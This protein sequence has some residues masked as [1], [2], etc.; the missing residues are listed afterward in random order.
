MGAFDFII[1]FGLGVGYMLD[2]IFEKY[3]SKII[4]VEPDINVMRTAFE[5]VDYSKYL[6][7]GRLFMTCDYDDVYKFY[8][9]VKVP[10]T[11]LCPCSKEISD[12]GAHNQR[13]LV[14][15]KIS[16]DDNAHIWIE[17]LVKDIE[18]CAS[19]EIYSLLKREDE[20]FVTEQ[21]YN[22]PKFVEDLLRDVIIKIKEKPEIRS[23]ELACESCESIHNHSTWA[24]QKEDL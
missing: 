9:G 19:S 6:E 14:S 15:L 10:V 22:N 4:L 2:Y 1:I 18:T 3:N 7:S 23:F 16:Y 12:N 5:M 24:Y 20:K 13:S 8:L 11:T 21:A 17:D